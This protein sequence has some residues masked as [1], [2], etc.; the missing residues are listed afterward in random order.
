[1]M[2]I[3]IDKL[4]PNQHGW[5]GQRIDALGGITV[6]N[7]LGFPISISSHEPDYTSTVDPGRRLVNGNQATVLCSDALR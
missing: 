7:T 4:C 3:K 5:F 2:D 6:N 1:M